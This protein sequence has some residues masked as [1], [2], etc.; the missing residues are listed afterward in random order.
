MIV[1]KNNA[2]A[3]TLDE[4]TGAILQLE[5]CLRGRTY[6]DEGGLMPPFRMEKDGQML[7]GSGAFTYTKSEDGLSLRWEMDTA[8]VTADIHLLED[9]LSFTATLNNKL[10]E[11]FRALEYPILENVRDFGM[12]GF[13]AHSYAT[14]VLC[15]FQ[16]PMSRRRARCVLRLIRRA[17]PV[18]R[19]S[20]SP[21]IRR[22]GEGFTLR[23][24]TG[25]PIKSG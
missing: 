25:R 1:L 15:R 5:D 2:A 8:A 12:E 14:G 16:P 9:G 20:F 13:L 24:W 21:T 17:F 22:I 19:C 3:L 6:M 7:D 23:R 10:G 11:C 4:K 18:R